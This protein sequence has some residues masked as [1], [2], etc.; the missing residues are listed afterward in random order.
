MHVSFK[1][2]H[3]ANVFTVTEKDRKVTISTDM[4]VSEKCGIAASKCNQI[5]WLIKR[6]YLCIKL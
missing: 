5:F 4:T 3:T 1:M 2:G 6:I